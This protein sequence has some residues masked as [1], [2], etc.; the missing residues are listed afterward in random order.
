MSPVRSESAAPVP[1]AVAM[2]VLRS[3]P[4][5][6]SVRDTNE[7]GLSALTARPVEGIHALHARQP[8]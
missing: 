1:Q 7:D 2:Q 8:L 4:T 3:I 6:K 5:Y